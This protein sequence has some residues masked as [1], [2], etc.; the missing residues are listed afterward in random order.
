[1]A[2]A[3]VAGLTVRATMSKCEVLGGVPSSGETL[4]LLVELVIC[5][6]AI[7]DGVETVRVVYDG[8][9][10]VSVGAGGE[11]GVTGVLGLAGR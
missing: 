10:L 7:C 8:G 11:L 9:V 2:T 5:V 6:L 1:M 3:V 4:A